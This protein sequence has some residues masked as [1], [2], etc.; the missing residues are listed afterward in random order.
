MVRHVTMVFA[1]EN[2]KTKK[3]RDA[4][5]HVART[6]TMRRSYMMTEE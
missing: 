1:W 6:E 3:E 5:R 4:N 2:E